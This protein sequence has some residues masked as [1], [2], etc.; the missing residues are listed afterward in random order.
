MTGFLFKQPMKV[1]NNPI[2]YTSSG[3]SETTNVTYNFTDESEEEGLYLIKI[4][5]ITTLST[6]DL[7]TFTSWFEILKGTDLL[8]KIGQ[9]TTD[10][11][12]TRVEFN[13]MFAGKELNFLVTHSIAKPI[14]FFYRDNR[15]ASHYRNTTCNVRYVKVRDLLTGE[16]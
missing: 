1:W 13:T 3:S 7:T 12:G 14:I 4:S 8:N 16:E 10:G 5:N 6:Q 15:T 2:T 9:S 11:F